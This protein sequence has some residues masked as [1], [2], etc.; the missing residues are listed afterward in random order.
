ME[1][2]M[3]PRKPEWLRVRSNIGEESR[4]VISLLRELS[5]HTVCE[6][7]H[8]PNCG[9][10]FKKRTATFMILGN[11]CTR[12]CTFCTVAK[13]APACVDKEEPVRFKRIHRKGI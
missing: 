7:A 8:C 10:C 3:P 1:R 5:L 11:N 13:A 12:N 4:K 9:E 2:T 6:E